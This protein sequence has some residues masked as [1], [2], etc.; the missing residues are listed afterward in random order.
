MSEYKP[1]RLMGT[2]LLALHSSGVVA[3]IYQ[4]TMG[5]GR[6]VCEAYRKDL[7]P[8]RE[9]TPMACQRQYAPAAAGFAAP[10]W[11]GL[12]PQTHLPLLSKARIYLQ[13]HNSF[14]SAMKLS[15]AEVERDTLLHL[16]GWV[17]ANHVELRTAD[18][19]LTGEGKLRKV[20]AMTE[21]GCGPHPVPGSRITRLFVLNTAAT[22]ID[23]T[24]PR[25]WN[26]Y[27]NATIE[28]YRGKPYVEFYA[29]DDNWGKLLTGSGE[30][31]VLRFTPDGVARVCTFSWTPKP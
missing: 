12:D 7:E 29:A 8:H 27:Y 26:D 17:Q 6:E 15:D 23:T 4:L 31:D 24:A 3:G 20:L 18:L 19:D 28:L 25:S 5:A 1:L 13:Q 22:D 16:R 9:A 2:L 14:V 30:L 21:D 11:Q 10:R